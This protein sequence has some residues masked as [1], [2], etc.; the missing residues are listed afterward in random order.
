MQTKDLDGQDGLAESIVSRIQQGDKNAEQ[1]LVATYY[2]GIYFILNRQTKNPSLSEDLA[3][4]TFILVIQKAREGIINNPAAINAF[5]RQIAVNLLIAYIRKES[6]RDTHSVEDIEIH[7]PTDQLEISRAIHSEKTLAL[8]EQLI[9]EL[10]TD[11]DRNILRSYF[12][13]DLSKQQICEN[14]DLSLEHFDRVLFRARQRLKQLISHKFPSNSSS[15]GQN[16]INTLLSVILLIGIIEA[17]Q[18]TSLNLFAAVVREKQ[19]IRH[20]A[21]ETP[22]PSSR[23]IPLHNH[24][25]SGSQGKQFTPESR[26]A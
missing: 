3:Q 16:T 23:F 25:V 10:P 21:Y 12:V 18:T 6:R 17:T 7:A 26:C 5:I 2:R 8:V 1:Q 15:N 9:N 4:D 22:E 14:L 24:N 11:R 13:Y 20:L 19:C